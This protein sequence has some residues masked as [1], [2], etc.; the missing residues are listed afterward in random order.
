MKANK[1]IKEFR[2]EPLK[3]L[4]E[5]RAELLEQLEA[6]IN[7]AKEEKRAIT[8]EEQKTFD[9][10]EEKIKAVDATIEAEKRAIALKCTKTVKKGEKGGEEEEGNDPEVR[11]FESYLRNT[12]AEMRTG[13]A[14]MV[15]GENGA[16]VPKSVANKIIE[17]VL[18]ICPIYKD[19]EQYSVKGTLTIPYYDESNSQI[20]CGYADDFDEADPSNGKFTA[21]TLTGFL[22]EAL[23]NVG[24]R[25]INNSDFDIVSFV[26]KK[27]AEAI[28]KFIE[29]ELLIGTENKIEGLSGL[30]EEQIM[31]SA[32]ATAI[33]ADELIDLQEMIPDEYQANAYFI[34]NKKT[35]TAIRKLKDGEGNY[36]LQKDATARWGYRLFGQDVYTTKTL[37]EVK[38]AN[39]G[40]IAVYYGDMTGLATKVS[41]EIEIEVLRETMATK[42]AVQIVGFVELDAKVQNAEKI[43]ALKLKSA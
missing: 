33:T 3:G 20:V 32:A 8:E 16:V 31:E 41:E 1:R 35:R 6:I 14:Q 40:K 23:T 2:A 15:I 12:A 39:A 22:G 30:A 24:K 17:K 42:H 25:L 9:E 26:I 18:E 29:K 5:Q 11:A 21:I 43:A 38:A 10:L 28:A 19:S 36:L 27:V 37:P 13:E 4:V 34:M 7:T